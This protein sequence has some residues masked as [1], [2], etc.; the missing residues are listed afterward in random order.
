MAAGSPS[1]GT[2]DGEGTRVEAVIITLDGEG[3]SELG[4][5]HRGLPFCEESKRQT[6]RDNQGLIILY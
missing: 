5:I 2:V 1:A 6:N 3:V 4:S